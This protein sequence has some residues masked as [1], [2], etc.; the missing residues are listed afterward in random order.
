MKRVYKVHFNNENDCIIFLED[1]SDAYQLH[2]Y[3]NNK[4]NYE[5]NGLAITKRYDFPDVDFQLHG[6][7]LSIEL[8]LF[9]DELNWDVKSIKFRSISN[10]EIFILNCNDDFP[11]PTLRLSID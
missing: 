4:K 3:P 7:I 10:E 1:L 8:G 5:M 6:T 9:I 2:L 11:E